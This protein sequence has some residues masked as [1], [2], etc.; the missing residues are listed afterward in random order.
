MQKKSY[1]IDYF[2][3]ISKRMM[4]NLLQVLLL[5]SEM[6]VIDSVLRNHRGCERQQIEMHIGW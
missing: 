2:K 6:K 3:E 1:L 4:W 5:S